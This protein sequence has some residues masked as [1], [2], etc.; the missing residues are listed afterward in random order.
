MYVYPDTSSY[1]SGLRYIYPLISS[2]KDYAA[3][4]KRHIHMSAS[5]RSKPNATNKQ[6]YTILRGGSHYLIS[7]SL[8]NDRGLLVYRYSHKQKNALERIIW[9]I[10]GYID[11]RYNIRYI[12]RGG[13]W[14][15]QPDDN[16]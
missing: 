14:D 5:K 1:F 16:R 11:Y 6:G 10:T 3:L 15:L 7:L 13:I 8:T 9:T 4:Q 12:R 2:K